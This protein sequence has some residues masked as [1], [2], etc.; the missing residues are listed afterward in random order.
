MSDEDLKHLWKSQPADT[1]VMTEQELW[2]RANATQRGVLRRNLI[3]GL[4]A[5]F[6]IGG[7][8]RYLWLFPTPLMRTGCVLIILA[9]LVV[10]QQ[11][12]RRASSKPMPWLQAGLSCK[13]FH[14][15]QLARQRDALRSVWLWYVAPF[16][17]GLVVFRWGVE[18]ELGA[19]APFAQGWSANLVIVAVLAAIIVLNLVAAQR[20]QR[21]IDQLDRQQ[22]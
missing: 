1:L 19:G 14:R 16:V 4:A 15:G 21:Q 5:L 17:P 22:R 11:L 9:T 8:T 20:L 7:F 12:R 6:V 13:E 18:T 10:M 3:E 2:R